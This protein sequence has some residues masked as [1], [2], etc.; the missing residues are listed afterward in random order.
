[1]RT[2][3]QDVHGHSTPVPHLMA[4]VC[5]YGIRGLRLVFDLQAE[6]AMNIQAEL[7]RRIS[8]MEGR[9]VELEVIQEGLQCELKERTAEL[10]EEVR[11]LCSIMRCVKHASAQLPRTDGPMQINGVSCRL[12]R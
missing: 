1:M 10:R 5:G 3:L 4:V 8:V 6:V 11:C 12:A 2:D 7:E 9:A